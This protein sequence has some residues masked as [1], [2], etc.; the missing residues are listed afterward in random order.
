MNTDTNK[1]NDTSKGCV[2]VPAVD[3]YETENEYSLRFDMPGVV[4]E[5]LDVTL[6]DTE[7]E[8]KGSVAPYA[9]EG[10]EL[11]Y[12]EYSTADFY[13]KFRIGNDV[14]KNGIEA[15]LNNGVL[16]LV[17]HKHEEVKPRKIEIGTK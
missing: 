11:K 15:S 6:H 10:K 4:K 9:P 1:N 3:V 13:R 5:N 12:S 14:D 16:S 2:L 8:I 7:L 17:L